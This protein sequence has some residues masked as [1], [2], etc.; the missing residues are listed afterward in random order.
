MVL[1]PVF[2]P[3]TGGLLVEHFG[4]RWIFFINI[5]VGIVAVALAW[6]LLPVGRAEAAGKLD[7]PGSSCSQPDCRPHL[8][9]GEGRQR[10]G[11]RVGQ[12]LGPIA[13]GLLLTAVFVVHSLRSEN[14][15]L[16]VRLYANRAFAAAS[17]PPSSSEHRSSAP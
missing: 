3:V 4:W 17:A 8:R 7:V 10:R 6:K 15:L 9:P 1:A 2:G 13:I 5:P 11:L 14:P 16:N 12:A